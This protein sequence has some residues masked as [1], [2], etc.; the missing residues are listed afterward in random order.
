MSLSRQRSQVSGAEARAP[1]GRCPS[2]ACRTCEPLPSNTGPEEDRPGVPA[3]W[4]PLA[5]ASCPGAGPALHSCRAE[6]LMI[7]R[8][9]E[10]M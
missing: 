2:R 5:P 9:G 1:F 10:Q 4:G 8:G 3:P 6:R 7:K